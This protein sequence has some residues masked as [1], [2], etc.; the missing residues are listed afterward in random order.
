MKRKNVDIVTT[1]ALRQNLQETID[2]VYY[3]DN[4]VIVVRHNKPRAII[5][6]LPENDGDIDKIL[7]AYKKAIKQKIAT[8]HK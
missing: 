1:T 3:T 5:A 6:P 2:Q 4:P 8:E 7:E